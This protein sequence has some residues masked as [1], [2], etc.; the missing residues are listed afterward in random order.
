ME[1]MSE[2]S[3]I[4]LLQ[5]SHEISQYLKS[6]CIKSWG[7]GGGGMEGTKERKKERNKMRYFL[8]QGT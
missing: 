5:A 6:L 7:G 2:I 3:Y 1:D 4:N 8:L